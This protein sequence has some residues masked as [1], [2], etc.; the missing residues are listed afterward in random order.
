MPHLPIAKLV[1]SDFWGCASSIERDALLSDT[2]D[3]GS[4]GGLSCEGTSSGASRAYDRHLTRLT[5]LTLSGDE[6][7]E[8]MVDLM[9]SRPAPVLP[10]SLR[11]LRQDNVED[12][13]TL[14]QNK[15]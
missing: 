1:P 15:W 6:D 9:R 14:P 3:Y 13:N 11:V 4:E 5:E 7:G 10:A 2:A 8:V 12:I